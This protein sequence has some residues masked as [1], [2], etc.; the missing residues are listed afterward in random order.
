M[1]R[2]WRTCAAGGTR[3]LGGLHA[4]LALGM[5]ISMGTVSPALGL[6][7]NRQVVSEGQ[8]AWQVM[9]ICG[10]P[11][12]VEEKIETVFVQLY[13]EQFRRYILSPLYVRKTQWTYNFGSSRLVYF[14]TFEEGTLRQIHTGGYG[15]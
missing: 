7:C 13:D 2:L 8:T 6:T 15:R 11:T 9:A 4:I 14:L 1:H 3:L 12:H 5:T 10:E